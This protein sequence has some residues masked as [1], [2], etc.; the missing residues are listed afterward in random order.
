MEGADR[1]MV[2]S[3]GVSGDVGLRRRVAERLVVGGTACDAV[4]V[5]VDEAQVA[6]GVLVCQGDD[7]GPERRS[8]GARL[9]M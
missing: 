3:Q 9:R 8:G 5:S 4:D 6:T 1:R 2:A 7:G